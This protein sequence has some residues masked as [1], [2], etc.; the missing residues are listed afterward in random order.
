MP[1]LRAWSDLSLRAK[2]LIVVAVPAVA[3]VAIACTSLFIENRSEAADLEADQAMRII[4][5]SRSMKATET[6]VSAHIRAYFITGDV[7]F[8]NEVGQDAAGFDSDLLRLARLVEA[9]PKQQQEVLRVG[10]LH[11]ARMAEI[12]R[13]V[14]RFRPAVLSTKELIRSSTGA[15]ETRR[16]E[17][18][19]VLDAMEGDERELREAGRRM[20][21]HRRSQLRAAT[22]IFGLTGVLGGALISLLFA[23]GI[24]G[25]IERLGRNVARL[26]SGRPLA[27]LPEGKD[28]I[29]ALG[30][31]LTAAAELLDH[32]A[33]ALENALHGIAQADA[34][35]HYI[36]FNKAFGE[37][38]GFTPNSAPATIA[39]SVLAEDW[40]KMAGALERMRLTGRAETEVRMV[41][42][43]GGWVSVGVTLLPMP[44][45]GGSGCYVFLRDIT[46]QKE[47]EAALMRAKNA[48]LDASRAKHEFLAKVSH[49]I[50]TPLNAIMGAA[51]L[52]SRT[53]LNAEQSEY[54]AMFQRN[55][56]RLVSLIN[57]FLDLSKI[58]AGMVKVESVPFR[59]RET[60]EDAV[61]T[62]RDMA[63][64]KGVRLYA[65][66]ASGVP[67][68]ELGDPARLQQV[69]VNLLSNA[70]KFT[71]A[72]HVG[73]AVGAEDGLLHFDVFDTG[74]GIAPEDQ[75]RVFAAFIQLPNQNPGA[76]SGSGLGLAICKE[77]VDL[78]GGTIAVTS[79][80]GRGSSF[81]FNLP[82]RPVKMNPV[83]PRLTVDSPPLQWP[84]D[85]APA[86][87]LIADDA[88][89]NRLL[90]AAFLRDVPVEIRFAA[91]GRQA[92]DAVRGGGNFDLILMDIDMPE[93]D[94]YQATAA[95][96]DWQRSR[97]VEPTP[98]VALS[99]YTMHEAVSA[100]LKAGCV[101][102]LAK[103]VTRNTLL[104]AILRHA[105]HTQ[106]KQP[107]PAALPAAPAAI[108]AAAAT[109][110]TAPATV[111]TAPAAIPVAA[112]TSSTAPATTPTAPVAS[113]TAEETLASGYLAT[114]PAQIQ[115]ARDCLAAV[116]FAPIRRFGHNLKGTGCGY[117]FPRIG[118]IG[119]QIEQAATAG[120]AGRIAGQLEAL[121]QVVNEE[122]RK[123]AEVPDRP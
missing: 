37:L 66:V 106:R 94:G 90:L 68:W 71:D 118:A 5:T 91:D 6:E 16:I 79:E 74:P 120:D 31:G 87:I 64:Q 28:E 61:A 93:M 86:R 112:A 101:A 43:G 47:V 19:G 57:G 30:E 50:R 62:F 38:L 115:Q 95:I 20:A 10:A 96:L 63:F 3:T 105:R 81:H 108:P 78:M 1:W 54:V 77:L 4:E 84:P 92:V 97:G 110:P 9:N 123:H 51:D 11:R 111:P 49:D 36:S 104:D 55:C 23:S 73:L 2:G 46:R 48:A 26:K 35:G 98:I 12:S 56:R 67:E 107:Q 121:S 122:T 45:S 58:Q 34:S 39:S 60:A 42:S 53:A 69:L 24:T 72:G 41:R 21:G 88:A 117:G 100:S 32:R 89:D 119:L 116:D 80:L 82:L 33:A 75:E 85:R 52:L 65:S 59:V 40:W 113:P 29:G 70:L 8:W 99:A 76:G 25:R 83:E 27:F 102:H 14:A 109:S 18:A 17:M 13:A 7:S 22:L 114:K 15:N 44:E 103:P